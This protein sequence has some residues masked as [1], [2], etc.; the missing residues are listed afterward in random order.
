MR[1]TGALIVLCACLLEIN[2]LD[3][4]EQFKVC[5]HL[6][7]HGLLQVSRAGWRNARI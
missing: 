5:C 1:R 3:Q 4:F 2:M 7:L 6:R